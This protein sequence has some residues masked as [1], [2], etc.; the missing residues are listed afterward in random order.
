MERK[1]EKYYVF[2]IYLGLVLAPVGIFWQLHNCDFINYDDPVYVTENEY[3]KAGLS[4]ESIIWAFTKPHHHMWHPITS[5][6]HILDCQLFGLNP[7]GHHLTNLLLHIA[8]TL[9]LFG[10]LKRIC[11]LIDMK[12]DSMSIWRKNAGRERLWLTLRIKNCTRF[13]AEWVPFPFRQA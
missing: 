2:L 9:L 8:N 12:N 3:V 13:T 7:F 6:S 5:L 1:A 10:I 11:L 4:R